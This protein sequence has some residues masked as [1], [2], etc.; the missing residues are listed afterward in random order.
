MFTETLRWGCEAGLARLVDAVVDRRVGRHGLR[1]R[2]R[3]LVG[4]WLA[5]V[6][7]VLLGKLDEIDRLILVRI[8]CFEASRGLNRSGLRAKKPPTG[9]ALRHK[10]YG[11]FYG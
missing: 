8:S 9:E 7:D 2:G 1:L 4:G 6:F 5:A 11:G 3:K 10:G